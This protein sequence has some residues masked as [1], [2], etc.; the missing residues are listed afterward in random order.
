MSPS[1]RH[2]HP[3]G[4]TYMFIH[5]VADADG[6]GHLHE[7]WGYPP[8]QSTWPLLL[9]YCP[10]QSRHCVFLRWV[11]CK[12]KVKVTKLWWT[13]EQG[14]NYKQHKLMKLIDDALKWRLKKV[15]ER[16]TG[17]YLGKKFKVLI[18]N[19]HETGGVRRPLVAE[20]PKK[21]WEAL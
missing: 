17:T 10:E 12:V 21:L 18:T 16:E 1:S 19:Y 14:S 7:V 15:D 3:E 6:R 2:R 11:T 13:C 4:F 20:G 5:D 8:V 9:Q